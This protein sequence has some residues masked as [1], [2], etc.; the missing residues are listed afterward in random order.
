M[1]GQLFDMCLILCYWS[2][3]TTFVEY[4]CLSLHSF[5]LLSCL[6][7][8]LNI[9]IFFPHLQRKNEMDDT[10][11]FDKEFELKTCTNDVRV[12]L[13]EMCAEAE[14]IPGERA[15]ASVHTFTHILHYFLS[16][17]AEIDCGYV[18]VQNS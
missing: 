4:F 2:K 11:Y 17:L 18:L 14:K 3:S 7:S 9:L 16:S 6:L 8:L 1:S 10:Y 5:H 13:L 15:R 12:A